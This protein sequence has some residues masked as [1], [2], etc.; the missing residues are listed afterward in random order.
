MV[1]EQDVTDCP[2]GSARSQS[3]FQSAEI[4]ERDLQ[5]RM[6]MGARW[7]LSWALMRTSSSLPEA[8]DMTENQCGP[9][10]A[11]LFLT[12]LRRFPRADRGIAQGWLPGRSSPSSQSRC[13]DY[14]AKLPGRWG[15]LRCGVRNVVC[16]WLPR[17]KH[18][19]KLW[20]GSRAVV[21]PAC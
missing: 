8:R 15:Q 6:R 18:F 1:A 21:C 11:A 3:A 14:F 12:M 7:S 16:G 9:P 4:L 17:C 5:N 2:K 20:R 10:A 19:L 13:P